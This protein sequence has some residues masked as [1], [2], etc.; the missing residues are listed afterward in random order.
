MDYRFLAEETRHRMNIFDID[1]TIVVTT[2]KILV[3]DHITQEKFELTTHEF[4]EYKRCPLQD[5]DFSQFDCPS[6]LRAGLIIDWVFEILKKTVAIDKA[7]GIITARNDATLIRNF[8]LE[9]GI[10]IN[11][12][13]I[14]AVNDP[15]LG[16]KGTNAERKQIAFRKIIEMGFYEFEFFDDDSENLRLAKELEN[17]YDNVIIRTKHIKQKW[18][19]KIED[20]DTK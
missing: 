9:N 10:D 17:E 18:I 14:W 13:F 5:L 7:V 16:S 3:T 8:L 20:S 15:N 4:N 19:P 12:D 2:A 6:I 1:D 11:P